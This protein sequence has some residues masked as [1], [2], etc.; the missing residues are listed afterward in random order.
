[1]SINVRDFKVLSSD[2]VHRLAGLIYEPEG[3]VKGYFHVVHGMTDHIHRYAPIMRDM[4][5]LGFICFG[6]DHIGHGYTAN[7]DSELGYIA[8]T[9]GWD[10][11]CR[12]VKVF[13]DAVKAE[14]GTDV[15][16]VLMGHSMGSFIVRI[17]TEKY[18]RPDKLIIMG[19]G[20]KNPAAPIALV[21][22][23]IIRTFFGDKHISPLMN[24]LAFG[25]YNK[26][27]GG[28]SE[29]DPKP[30]LTCD[31]SIRQVYYGDKFCTFDFTVTAMGDLIRIMKKV[32]GK[33]W[34]ASVS[35]D[36]PILIVSGTDDPVGSYGKGVREVEDGLVRAGCKA[37]CI[38]YEG[39]RH[40]ILNDNSKERATADIL[41]FIEECRQNKTNMK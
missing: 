39:A 24:K 9:D 3:E 22:I 34:Y 21:L 40:E 29:A 25:S 32:N 33:A 15:P 2:G 13:S 14:Y 1:M 28:G 10:L 19:T 38:L 8:K 35:K 7:D 4:A 36:L 18:V 31:E 12:D 20:G 11:L 30:W 17:A 37:K 23:K 27:F 5:E 26:R 16:Y 6:Y 41:A